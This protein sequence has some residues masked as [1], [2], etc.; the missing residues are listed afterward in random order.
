MSDD[1][2]YYSM[3]SSDEDE[4]PMVKMTYSSQQ[5]TAPQKKK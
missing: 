5:N 3:S 1:A 2:G 4:K